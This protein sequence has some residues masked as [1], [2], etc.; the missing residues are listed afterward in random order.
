MGDR[1]A[2]NEPLKGAERAA[3]DRIVRDAG[4]RVYAYV[5][6]VFPNLDAEEIVSETFF[7]ATRNMKTLMMTERRVFYLLAIA[8]NLCRDGLRRRRPDLV[9][10]T[11]LDRRPDEDA[12]PDEVLDDPELRRSLLAAIAQLPD[13]QREIVVL[14]LSSELRFEQI[15][16]L[17]HV[18]LG[19]VLSRM[20]AATRRLSIRLGC[21]H[22]P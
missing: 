22:E 4:P 3:L 6:R 16:E 1:S 14:R 9:A 21:F 10:N 5:R 17:L 19:T 20:H 7:R 15:A 18:P 8:R 2:V 11:E 12:R 13:A